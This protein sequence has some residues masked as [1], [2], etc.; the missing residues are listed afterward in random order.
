MHLT[1]HQERVSPSGSMMSIGILNQLGRPNLDTLAVLVREAVQ[2]SW[3]ARLANDIPVFF[4]I[5][6]WMM[7]FFNPG[8]ISQSL[9]QGWKC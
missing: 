3:D 8:W 6:G 7:D 4:G 9:D 2:N 1:L 5:N